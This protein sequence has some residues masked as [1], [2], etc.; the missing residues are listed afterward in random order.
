MKKALALAVLALGLLLCSIG[1]A[2]AWPDW[3]AVGSW[4]FFTVTTTQDGGD[5]DIFHYLVTV[6]PVSQQAGWAIKAFVPYPTDIATQPFSQGS[7]DYD[8]GNTANWDNLNGGWEIGKFDQSSDDNA[9]FGWQTGSPNTYLFSGS[10]ATFN[11]DLGA[12]A[13]GWD[14]THFA[15][16]VVPPGGQDTFWATNGGPVIPE[17]SSLALICS[18]ALSL[19]SWAWLTKRRRTR[20]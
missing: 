14:Q 10:S 16:H 13:S 4:P 7:K 3:N 19:G 6:D 20:G 1:P 8:A 9:A 17:P 2:A 12:A 15:V 18:G 5:P 11:A